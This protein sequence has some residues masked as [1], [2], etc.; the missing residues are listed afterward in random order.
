MQGRGTAA[1]GAAVAQAPSVPVVA[2]LIVR[3][4]VPAHGAADPLDETWHCPAV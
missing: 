4:S 2:R 1:G 3:Y